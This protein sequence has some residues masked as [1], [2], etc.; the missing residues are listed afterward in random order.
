MYAKRDRCVGHQQTC[1]SSELSV[2]AVYVWVL[3]LALRNCGICLQPQPDRTSRG[4]L[5]H[6]T[7]VVR[8]SRAQLVG[9]RRRLAFVWWDFLALCAFLFLVSDVPQCQPI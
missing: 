5:F 7:L 8:A 4:G 2:F 3:H 1:G 9:E 6:T